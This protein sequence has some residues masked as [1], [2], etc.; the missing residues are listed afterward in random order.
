MEFLDLLR[1][2]SKSSPFAVKTLSDESK[3][4][5]L[6]LF[7]DYLYV[8]TEIEKDF[9]Q[10]LEEAL[11][12]QK[13]IIFLCGSSGDGKSEILTRYSKNEKYNK[14]AT[15][16]LDA[17]HSFKPKETAIERLDILFEDYTNN[18]KILIVGINTGML[19]NYAHA[20]KNSKIKE[21]IISYL[22]RKDFLGLNFNEEIEFL[23][24]KNY[25]NF[26]F[27]KNNI[28]SEFLSEIYTKLI[29]EDDGNLLYKKYI[30]L[31][32]K[33]TIHAVNYS[34]LKELNIEK[35]LTELIFS[36]RLMDDQFITTRSLL[37]LFHCL[38]TSDKFV[39]DTLF[40]CEDNEIL[41][42]IKRFDPIKI[43]TKKIDNFIMS[44][45]M[46]I[47][48]EK[49]EDYLNDLK[50]IGV[51]I[52]L[53]KEI[54]SLIRLFFVMQGKDF[55]N[56]YHNQFEGDLEL[57]DIYNYKD[58]WLAH[59]NLA[60]KAE[61]K[62]INKLY[63]DRLVQAINKYNSR[64]ISGINSDE[65]LL[66]T[67]G[68]FKILTKFEI[69]IDKKLLEMMNNKE[70]DFLRCPVL[71]NN[72]RK[73]ELNLNINLFKLIEMINEGYQPNKNDKNTIVMLDYIIEQLR[74]ALI[75]SNELIVINGD[76]RKTIKDIYG[77]ASEIKVV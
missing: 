32:N 15:F 23:D 71:V 76:L 62:K 12:G 30:A 57:K 47:K 5:E 77:D 56:N 38:L 75:D 4:G 70:I 68:E 52:D 53:T 64:N 72:K 63:T 3:R 20:G 50:K 24:F 2:L 21:I 51:Y 43:R 14:K 17:T 16:H 66:N 54:N 49:L 11:L 22:E 39:F 37:D 31:E 46:G 42:K 26:K 8:K 45:R 58:I 13:K 7:K 6:Q 36:V 9:E 10:K 65:F 35:K 28:K 69:I 1:V 33:K 73:I 48:D 59:K 29:D 61:F 74:G 34:F 41:E 44:I 19:A 40:E 55:S 27:Y 67:Y 25:P 60:D 18:E